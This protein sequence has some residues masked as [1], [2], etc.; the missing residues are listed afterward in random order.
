VEP[1]SILHEARRALFRAGVRRGFVTLAE[2]EAQLPSSSMTSAER[3]LLYFS[4]NAIGVEIR[5]AGLSLA[6]EAG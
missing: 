3:W 1:D 5:G 4:L 6:S 2:I